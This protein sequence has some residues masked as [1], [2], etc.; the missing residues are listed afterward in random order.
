MRDKLNDAFFS[1]KIMKAQVLAMLVSILLKNA[2][3][4]FA[5]P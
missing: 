4:C 2:L 1:L 3:G 5:N